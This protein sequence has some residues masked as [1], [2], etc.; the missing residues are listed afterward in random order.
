ME[1]HSPPSDD[2]RPTRAPPKPRDVQ[3][4]PRR[5]PVFDQQ[6]IKAA[7]DKL[8]VTLE[9]APSFSIKEAIVKTVD[10][11]FVEV[12]EE[13]GGTIWYNKAHIISAKIFSESP[14]S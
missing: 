12:Y 14:A 6:L 13:D 9:I 7:R 3:Q 10:L 8:L 5:I 4:R 1:T 11:Y 2:P